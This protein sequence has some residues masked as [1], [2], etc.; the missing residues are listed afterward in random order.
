MLTAK[1]SFGKVY[2]AFVG[3]L[4]FRVSRKMSENDLM[5]YFVG[6]LQKLRNFDTQAA[7]IRRN[8]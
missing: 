1:F 7:D 6:R 8:F 4:L 2:T 3:N 5:C